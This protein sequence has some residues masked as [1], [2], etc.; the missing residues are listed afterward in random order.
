[1]DERRAFHAA[2]EGDDVLCA[3]D[4]RAEPALESGIESYIAGG[5]DDDIDVAGDRLC[6]FF[7]VAE[8]WLGDVTAF[9]DDLVVYEAFESAAVKFAEGIERR[10]GDDVVPETVFRLLLRTRADSEIDL[11]TFGKRWSSMLSVTLP[12]N[13]VLPIKKIFRSL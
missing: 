6:L 2:R 7:T 8:V 13:P 12:R 9:D 1:V 11:A 3:Y 5:V 4:I 10:S